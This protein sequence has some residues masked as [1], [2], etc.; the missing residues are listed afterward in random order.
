MT[1]QGV[2]AAASSNDEMATPNDDTTRVAVAALAEPKMGTVG[3]S[4]SLKKGG[5]DKIARRS[6]TTTT[7]DRVCHENPRVQRQLDLAAKKK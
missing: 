5:S 6:N 7:T 2:K 3:S 1:P 4:V